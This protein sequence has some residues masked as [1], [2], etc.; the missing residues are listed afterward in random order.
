MSSSTPQG[1]WSDE[2]PWPDQKYLEFRSHPLPEEESGDPVLV[3]R[4]L[5][6]IRIPGFLGARLQSGS[7]GISRSEGVGDCLLLDF[8]RGF[9]A[10]ADASERN[11]SSS[12]QFLQ[13]FSDLLT[14]MPSF[15]TDR[16]FEQ[17]EVDSLKRQ[18]IAGS[19]KLLASLSFRDGCTFT[20]IFLLKTRGTV[21]GLLFH[22]GDSFLFSCDLK[23]GKAGQITKNNFWMVGRSRR[24][25]QVE[26]L[27]IHRD[28][29]ILL[30]TDGLNHS[31]L[32]RGDSRE[33]SISRLFRTAR[34][35]E[36]PDRLFDSDEPSS[37]QW[38]DTAIIALDPN[39]TLD[40]PVCYLVGGTSRIEERVFQEGKKRGLYRNEYLAQKGEVDRVDCLLRM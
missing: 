8:S 9:F 19:E 37:S 24:F 12:H 22:T 20:G 35:E 40:F 17:K 6:A 31:P 25:F 7:S 29:R 26:D 21:S 5:R 4:H 28:I 27:P 13:Q 16:V 18:L 1:P 39:S 11:P 15:S 10:V 32:F 14:G 33:E 34:P 36:I 38:D 30:A 23:T 3:N 2:G